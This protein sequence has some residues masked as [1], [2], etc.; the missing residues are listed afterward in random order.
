[1]SNP[2]PQATI[3]IVDDATEN[4]DV[5]KRALMDEY[6]VRPAINGP[7]A[8]RL[9]L[10]EPQ[11]DLILLDI[12]MPDMDGYEVCRLLKRDPRTQE[13]PI[14]FI[15]AKSSVQDELEGLHMGAVDYITK[16]I[17][18]PIV[19]VRIKTH[20]ALEASPPGYRRKKSS[21]L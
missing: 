11:P 3:L 13:I 19:K 4:L 10:M 1:M 16:P 7:V 20:L 9:A 17:S 6:I 5:L 2:V 18:P 14:I 12:M 15:T 8:L 21:A